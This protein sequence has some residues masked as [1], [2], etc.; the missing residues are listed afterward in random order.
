MALAPE[1]KTRDAEVLERHGFKLNTAYMEVPQCETCRGW[2][3]VRPDSPFGFCDF[4]QENRRS[5]GVEG[6]ADLRTAPDFG[7]VQWES[8]ED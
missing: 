3:R 2:Y 4:A 7:C 8:K 6:P 1:L 5:F